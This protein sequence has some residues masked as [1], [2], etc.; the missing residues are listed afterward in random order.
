[1]SLLVFNPLVLLCVFYPELSYVYTKMRNTFTKFKEYFTD[2]SFEL[3]KQQ[4]QH[5]I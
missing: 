4:I 5:I 3:S 1:M 2:V